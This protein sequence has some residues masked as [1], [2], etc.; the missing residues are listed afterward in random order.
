MHNM[1]ENKMAAPQLTTCQLPPCSNPAF[2]TFVAG[3]VT[4]NVSGGGCETYAYSPHDNA[5]PDKQ[6]SVVDILKDIKTS[7]A[8]VERHYYDDIPTAAARRGMQHAHH[9]PGCKPVLC[10]KVRLFECLWFIGL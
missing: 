8:A 9:P 4:S 2:D 5:Q 1:N 10:P 6:M 3:R 7:E